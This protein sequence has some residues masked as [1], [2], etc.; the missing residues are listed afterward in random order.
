MDGGWQ[1]KVLSVQLS[2]GEIG[3]VTPTPQEYRNFIGGVGLAA[4]LLYNR[5]PAGADPLGPENV[6][7]IF[8]GPI[9]GTHFPGAGR[10]SVCALSPLTGH[11]GQSIAGG[12]LGVAIKRA[13]WDGILISGAA[14]SP[15]YLL[16]ENDQVQV[17][18]ASDLWGLDTFQTHALLRE[19][20]LHSEIICIGP[21]GEKLVPVA[22]LMQ[23]PG[24]S[25]GRCGMGAVFGSK[26][27]KAIVVHGNG[28]VKIADRRAFDDLIAR[29]AEILPELAQTQA[30]A[31]E[32][33]ASLV[34][35]VMNVGDM[36][37]RN[38]S[39][40]I[41][42][43]G[44]SKLSG[45]SINENIL[46][47]REGC[48]ACTIQCKG[49]VRIGD[50]AAEGP[51]PE[52]ETLG[53]LG[54]LLFHENLDGLAKANDLCNRLGLDTISAGS[55][56]AWAMEAFERGAL[57][58]DDTCGLK[59]T[60][61]DTQA[62]LKALQWI[63]NAEEGLG[64]LLGSGSR[65]AAEQTGKGSL[66]YAVQVK[67]LDMAMHNP[68]VFPGLALAYAF[69]PHGASHMEGGFI[70]RKPGVS[71]GK[72]IDESI[73]TIRLGTLT[74]EGVFCAFT[75]PDAPWNFMADLLESATGLDYTEQEL[76]DCT[77]RDYLL[78][79]AFNLRQGNTPEDNELPKRIVE[80]LQQADQRWIEEWPVFRPM[81]YQARGF[82]E[83]GYP[84]SQ[85][86]IDAGLEQ[87]IPDM[88]GWRR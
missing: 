58:A 61:A 72:F 49:I 86:L 82:D 81:Y 5:I 42:M 14:E 50:D 59:L 20:H 32:G 88:A 66:D 84:T 26:N 16:V 78:R 43:E 46:T 9:T 74:N 71:L 8:T 48:H 80:Q 45:E 15:C 34:M 79:Y 38:W 67:G 83:Q 13:G 7:G 21:A 2:T 6:V 17:K 57:T 52:Y 1:G 31:K 19:R 11:W 12:S 18:E 53:S 60:W 47:R 22:S 40:A 24:K 68:R 41:W 4:E 85:T 51:G 27:I 69:L 65:K 64:K 56:I 35:A 77:D 36:P 33:T 63:G 62:V 25:A 29:H 39:G 10:V 30:Y 76:R 73:E 87:V 23:R 54:S 55:A 37:V 70:Q 3:E 44:A 28:P 75:V